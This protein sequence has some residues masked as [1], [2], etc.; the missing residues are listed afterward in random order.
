[1]DAGG[2]AAN[3]LVAAG[4]TLYFYYYGFQSL[5]ADDAAR[6]IGLAT[7]QVGDLRKLKRYAG[8]EPTTQSEHFTKTQSRRA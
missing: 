5:G 6:G 1:W 8:V 4:D 2:V 3:R 7:C